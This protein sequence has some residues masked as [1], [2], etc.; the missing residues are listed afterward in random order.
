MAG[1]PEGAVGLWECGLLEGHA[2]ASEGRR[3]FVGLTVHGRMEGRHESRLRSSPA[4]GVTV[5]EGRSVPLRGGSEG[6]W[7]LSDAW[8]SVIMERSYGTRHFTY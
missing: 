8:E 2:F 5:T 6:K 7:D 4:V 3:I 1:S